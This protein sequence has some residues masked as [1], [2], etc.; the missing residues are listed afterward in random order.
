MTN[1]DHT[2][3]Q[4]C[5][6][7]LRPILNPLMGIVI[8]ICVLTGCTLGVALC[9]TSTAHAAEGGAATVA[10]ADSS[11]ASGSNAATGGE[12]AAPIAGPVPN[13]II[14]NF[15]YGEGSVPAGG[16]FNL[17][18]TFQNKGKVAISNM[19]VTVDGGESFAIA[20]GT[21]TFYVD[22]LYAGRSL[23]QSVPMQAVANAT[24]GAQ[25]I[26]VGFS[27]EY[28][29]AGARNANQSSITISVPVSQP[30]R[31]EVNEPVLPD[32]ATTGE[33]TT[34]TLNYVN[35]GKGDIS[36]VEATMEGEGFETTTATQY[37]G[38][39]ASGATGQIGYAFTPTASGELTA[40]LEVNYENSDG[41]PQTKEFPIK[42]PVSDPA[43]V[44]MGMGDPAM[45]EE[46]EAGLAWW[47]WALIGVGVLV[48]IILIIVLV[49]RRK[50][51]KGG[52][53]HHDIDEE[54]DE[55]AQGGPAPTAD[56]ATDTSSGEPAAGDASEDAT[57]VLPTAGADT[58]S[59]GDSSAHPH[60]G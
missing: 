46:P 13:I 2:V 18:F 29:D 22:A 51:R 40:T 36:N 34:I 16:A 31:F 45:Q 15:T 3:L 54:W 53:N 42:L 23:T 37:V 6:E 10:A 41:Q 35:K 1:H 33:E 30:D 19:V 21:N 17:A 4:R 48:V 49:V 43:P 20:G 12:T 50:R 47:I 24:S 60:K 52:K 58:V 11:G 26:T 27:Y 56:P 44:D 5:S 57:I 8:A 38:N 14:T 28:V 9:G 7:L 32:T 59:S 55:W 25:P 39:V